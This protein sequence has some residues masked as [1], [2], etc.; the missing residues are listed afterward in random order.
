MGHCL[1]G[2]TLEHVQPVSWQWAE[3]EREREA[4]TLILKRTSLSHIKLADKLSCKIKSTAITHIHCAKSTSTEHST[5]RREGFWWSRAWDG[6]TIFLFP[7]YF[8]KTPTWSWQIT[9]PHWSF[10]YSSSKACIVHKYIN[11]KVQWYHLCSW[12]T[13]NMT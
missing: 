6:A 2:L 11:S 7:I 1:T 10:S 5:Q 12:T 9:S 3:Q 8:K 4:Q 13:Y